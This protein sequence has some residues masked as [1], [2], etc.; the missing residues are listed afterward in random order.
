MPHW[1]VDS[2]GVQLPVVA[3][4]VARSTVIILAHGA[5]TGMDS[6]TLLWL[7]SFLRDAGVQVVR[8][9]FPYRAQ[10]KSMPDRMPTLIASYRAVIESVRA[11]LGPGR[12][13]IGGHSMGGRVASMLEA[14]G[15]TT[16]GLLLCSYPL[17]P[18]GQLEKLRDAHLSKIQVPTL[19]INGTQDEF[20]TPEIMDR[21]VATLDP[22]IWTMH[23]IEG[24]DHG[25][26]VKKISGRT[27]KEVEAEIR[28]TIGTWISQSI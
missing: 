28:E 17:H 9:N 6:K 7:S 22:D 26:G 13:I 25:Y 15:K 18:P 10:G 4:D 24:A 14:E 3:D 19:Q 12:L 27:K 21:I 11:Q 8:F 23:W 1:T 20:C 16:D 2:H 5:G